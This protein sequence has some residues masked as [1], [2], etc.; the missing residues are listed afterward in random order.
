[1]MLSIVSGRS[2]RLSNSGR[3]A[4]NTLSAEPKRSSNFVAA[5]GPTPG[6]IFSAIQSRIKPIFAF[7]L[8]TF[9]FD[10][11]GGVWESNPPEPALTVSQTV[12]KTA[13]DTSQDAPPLFGKK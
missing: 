1:M 5:R 4:L 13:P 11:G 9:A 6:V 7:C 2:L 10:Y 12:L 3:R 8:F